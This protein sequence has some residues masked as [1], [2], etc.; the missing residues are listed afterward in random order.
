MTVNFTTW[1]GITDGQRYEIP[2]SVVDPKENDLDHF[3]GDLGSFA[4]DDSSPVLS[5]VTAGKSVKMDTGD[6]NERIV[7]TSGLNAYPEQG[8]KFACLVVDDQSDLGP[9]TIFG[10]Q[11]ASNFYGVEIHADNNRLAFYKDGSTAEDFEE[12]VSVSISS[13]TWYDVEIEW[14]DD[15]S[16]TASV[17]DVDQTDGERQGDALES[18][19]FTDTDYSGGGVG[20]GGVSSGMGAWQN[21]RVTERL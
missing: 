5:D 21:Y 1:K 19:T 20:F 9:L 4:I 15:G 13:G 3:S 14:L 17:Y 7:S 6:A 10:A 18:V 11:D 2:D 8:E 16:M 12:S